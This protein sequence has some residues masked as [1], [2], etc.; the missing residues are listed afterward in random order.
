M[1]L[2]HLL[3]LSVVSAWLRDTLKLGE[4]GLLGS[5]TTPVQILATALITYVVVSLACIL[6]QKIPKLGKIIVG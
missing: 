5:W 4:E 2:S 1:Y 6:L 3:V